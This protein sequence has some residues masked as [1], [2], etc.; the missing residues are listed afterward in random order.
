MKASYQFDSSNQREALINEFKGNL[1]EYLVARD[2]ARHYGIEKNFRGELNPEYLSRLKD[3]EQWLR[4]NS[5]ELIT[6]LPVLSG[7]LVHSSLGVLPKKCSRIDLIGKLDPSLKNQQNAKEADMILHAGG[8]ER[9]YPVSLK[10]CKDSAYVNT[11]SAGV[12]SILTTY[13]SLFSDIERDQLEF[14]QFVDFS[15]NKMVTNLCEYL[16]FDQEELFEADSFDSF[17]CN[18]GLPALPGELSAELKAC[19]HQAYFEIA[20]ELSK[21]MHSLWLS[22][23]ELFKQGLLPLLGLGR[24]DLIS[25]TCFYKREDT[26]SYFFSWANCLSCDQMKEELNELKFNLVEHKLLSSFE[27]ELPSYRFQVR[28]KPMNRFTTPGFKVNFGLKTI[29]SRG[30]L[31]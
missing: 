29:K 13:F 24:E 16:D 15:F 4:L 5:K 26:E 28:I 1:F 2:L 9:L 21:K 25:L 23:P 18:Q 8:E 7:Q 17:W 11:K 20:K 31:N 6:K 10:L 27:I 30:L 14:N 19:V 3:Y 22:D 12:K